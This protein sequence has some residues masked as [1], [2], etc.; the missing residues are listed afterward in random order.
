MKITREVI[1]DLLPAYESGEAS[2]DTKQLVE[3]Y[4]RQDPGLANL[5]RDR[6]AQPEV[7]PAEPPDGLFNVSLA[8]TKKMLR[9]RSWLLTLGIWF[10]WA[11]FLVVFWDFERGGREVK[12]N[13]FMWRDQPDLALAFLVVA[14]C[15]WVGYFRLRRRLRTTSL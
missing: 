4:L 6:R 15:C 5:V 10:T 2:R 3:E 8:R 14:G 12:G 9:L 7:S 13:F 11:S 1:L